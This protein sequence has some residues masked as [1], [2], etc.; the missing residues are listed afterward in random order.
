[1]LLF[2]SKKVF[3][4]ANILDFL[5]AKYYLKPIIIIKIFLNYCN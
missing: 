3:I 1:M 4:Y 2:L 5:V